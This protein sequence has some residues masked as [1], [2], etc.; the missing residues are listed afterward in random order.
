[1]ADLRRAPDAVEPLFGV[2]GLTVPFTVHRSRRRTLVVQVHSDG[3]VRVCAPLFAPASELSAFLRERADWIVRKR[4]EFLA[5]APARALADGA[6]VPFLDE[7]LILRLRMAGRV[8]AWREGALLVAQGP[9]GFD[10]RRALI[11]FYRRAALAHVQARI[12]L[13]APAVGRV[14]A[15]V[16]IRDQKTRWGSCSARGTLS[17]NWRLMLGPARV[18]DYVIVHELCHLLHRHHRPSFWEAVARVMPDYRIHQRE[19]REIGLSLV[20]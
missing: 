18:M 5:R 19:L 4:E 2:D 12:P 13:F 1:M 8:R 16:V 10:P 15:R 11:P 7:S 20:L 6:V 17:F 9:A 14:P 3:R